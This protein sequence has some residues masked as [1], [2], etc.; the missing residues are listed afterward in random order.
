MARLSQS[1]SPEGMRT[2]CSVADSV[3]VELLLG[4]NVSMCQEMPSGVS[5]RCCGIVDTAVGYVRICVKEECG[6]MEGD[7]L[8]WVLLGGGLK[9]PV[10]LMLLEGRVIVVFFV[11]LPT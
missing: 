8:S 11:L 3:E 5:M 10:V 9:V 2:M 4:E 1:P 6:Q 7:L